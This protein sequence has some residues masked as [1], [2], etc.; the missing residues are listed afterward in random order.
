MRGNEE[1]EA[2]EGGGRK[3][4]CVAIK[5]RRRMLVKSMEWITNRVERRGLLFAAVCFSIFE[6]QCYADQVKE[7]DV[8]PA[9][10]NAIIAEVQ[11]LNARIN[12]LNSLQGRLKLAVDAEKSVVLTNNAHIAGLN[13]ELGAL[14]LKLEERYRQI[15]VLADAM[16]RFAALESEEKEISARHKVTFQK[17]SAA[18]KKRGLGDTSAEL[19]KEIEELERQMEEMDS[20][21]RVLPDEKREAAKRTAELKRDA[22]NKD[23]VCKAL[24]LEIRSKQI[25]I[26]ENLERLIAALKERTEYEQVGHEIQRLVRRRAVLNKA[27]GRL[28]DDSESVTKSQSD[29]MTAAPTEEKQGS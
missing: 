25:N 14:N 10:T 27:L 21:L 4:F 23:E 5:L 9:S 17:L 13:E 18:R 26:H 16:D 6:F 11:Q 22:S 8:I 12:E 28:S 19:Q 1:S 24:C 20:R 29:S 7:V 15:P 3:K 2:V